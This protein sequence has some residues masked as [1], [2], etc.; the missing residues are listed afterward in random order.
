MWVQVDVVLPVATGL[1]VLP[2]KVVWAGPE[3]YTRLLL[4][5]RLAL[6]WADARGAR[7]SGELDRWVAATVPLAVERLFAQLG[8]LASAE[9]VAELV[10]AGRTLVA[11]T[12]PLTSP[13]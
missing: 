5:D 10:H 4:C 13:N 8:T 1:A 3:V 9:A 7:R 2:V 6:T 12:P 11:A